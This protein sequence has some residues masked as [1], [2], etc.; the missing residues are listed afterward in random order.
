MREKKLLFLTCFALM[1]PNI[2]EG[3]YIVAQNH[4]TKYEQVINS[5]PLTS[6]LKKIEEK[7]CTKIIFSYEDLD[8]YRVNASVKATNVTDA[9]KQVL[10]GLPVIYTQHNGFISVKLKNETSQNVSTN[11]QATVSIIGKV[12]DSKGETIPSATIQVA[13]N[14][15]LGVVTDANGRFS[16]NLNQ[17]KGET[18]VVSYLGMKTTSYFVNCRKDID[19]IVIKLEED[20]QVLDDV[21][22]TGIYTRKAESFTGSA[23]TVSGND[24][25]RVSNQNVLQSLKNL[26][27]TVYIADNLTSGSDPNGS[28][29]ISM[30][31]TSSFPVETSSLK[32]T[33]Q[34]QPN[35]PLF[36]LD[37]FETSAERIKDL[38]MNRVES[39][40]ILKDASAKALYGSK[41][42]NGVI[43]IETKRLAGT[44]AR[45]T[46]NGS[47]DLE[48][49]DLSSYDMTNAMEKLQV[50]KF[51]GLYDINSAYYNGGTA[52][53][54][55]TLTTLYNQRY[56]LALEGLDTDWMAKPLRTG[57]GQKHNINIEL[58]DARNLRGILNFTYN[59][60]A[61]VMKGSNRRNFSGDVSLSYRRKNLLFKNILSV[62][63]N[64]SSDSPYG[65]FSD[66]VKMNP[67]WQAEDE[68][69]NILRWAESAHN[70]LSYGSSA[71]ANPL[72]DATIGTSLKSSYMEFV[73][74]FYAEWNIIPDL[75]AT[76]RIGAE[77]KRN[78][79]DEFY[80]ANHS[81]FAS[82]TK[83]SSLWARRGLYTME[84]GKQTQLS[85]DLNI[86][87]NHAFGKHHLFAN[88]GYFVSE[89][90]YQAYQHQAE[91]FGNESAA[92]ITFAH[93]YAENTT[94]TGYASINRE[95]SFLLSASYDY[96]DRYL[97]DLTE[98]ESASSLYGS[99]KRWANSW[100]V[101]LGWNLHNEPLLKNLKWLK[102]FKLRGSIG[103]T[104]NQNFNTNESI[105]T[106]RYFTGVNYEGLT[107]AYLNVMPNPGLMWE[108]KKDYNFGFDF[109]AFGLSLTFD[110]YKAD[111]KNMLTN[112]S[113][114]TSTGFNT[115]KDNLGLVRNSGV[116]IK[117]NYTPWQSKD[118]FVSVYGSFVYTKNRIVNLSESMREY[119]KRMLTLAEGENQTTPVLMYQDGLSMNTIWAVPS[120][121]IDPQTGEEIYIKKDGTYTYTYDSSDMIAA[122]DATPKYRGNIGFNAEYKGIGLTATCTY[123]AGGQMYNSTLV[124]RVEDADMIFNVDRRVLTG[125][126]QKPGDISQ[127]KG[128]SSKTNTRAT[129]RFVQ[130]R[131]ELTLSSISAYYEFPKSIYAKLY[132]Q[133]LRFAVYLNDVATFSSVKVE[134]GTSYPFARTLSFAL[135]ATF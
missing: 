69:G 45:I 77:Q 113:I 111:T 86:N 29:S 18:L 61:G 98:R 122:G 128:Y 93:Q 110:I 95:M 44:E 83:G 133:R 68:N 8:K 88:A 6:I 9:L 59:D 35:E 30:R 132:M 51:E 108:Q 39:I 37:G 21:V 71:I 76:L 66:Y 131:N 125:R 116:E 105:A 72:Y 123:L 70:T 82:Y 19:N 23:T 135:S 85:G 90:K 99:D 2:S 107:G 55:Q 31:G 67:Y 91:G 115:V 121:G 96:D 26:D 89:T 33:Y 109:R 7:F 112:V 127:Y 50:E 17:G 11:G 32:S 24:L 13:G 101:G 103:L 87:Y 34:N 56:K 134:R 16:L 92:D 4:Q 28:L 130:D 60:V 79:V 25:R 1:T 12:I 42:A 48:I 27:P 74:N 73:D 84:N 119:N 81:R 65:T 46:Y 75:K 63:S 58:G 54:Q 10:K 78:D 38:D 117:A 118:G 114:P 15:D 53:Q 100:S 22:V 43:V 94:P 102:L 41:A 106:Y 40:T 126:W 120:A 124:D 64:H 129:T 14:P 49:P 62:V 3:N 80:P 97:V 5:K 20:K 104:G 47:L 52:S 36:I 57:V